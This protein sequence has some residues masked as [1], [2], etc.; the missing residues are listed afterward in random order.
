LDKTDEID[1]AFG[2]LFP[3][4]VKMDKKQK[5]RRSGNDPSDPEEPRNSEEGSEDEKEESEA[6]SFNSK[7]KIGPS[8]IPSPLPPSFAFIIAS[9]LAINTE[10]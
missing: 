3:G 5:S 9:H 2:E 7:R 8:L 4:L 10:M 6:Q 1:K